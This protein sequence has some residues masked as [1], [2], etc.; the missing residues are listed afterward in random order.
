MRT[1]K[2]NQVVKTHFAV[3]DADGYTKKTG[4][5]GACVASLWLNGAV[6]A[7][8]VTIAE[9]GTS[10]EYTATFTPNAVG[11]WHIEV[12]DTNNTIWQDDVEARVA[13]IDLLYR[14]ETGR[15]KIDKVSST[16][17]FYAEDGVTPLIVYN[18]KDAAGNP[19]AVWPSETVPFE[20]TQV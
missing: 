20:R 11:L 7:V 14:Y 12:L 2:V 6:S 13:D 19:I 9:I 18:L 4:Q 8:S 3:F 15:W 5:A 17:T 10:G 16:M 1:C